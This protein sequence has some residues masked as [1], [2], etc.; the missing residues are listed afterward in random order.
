MA[1]GILVSLGRGGCQA[2]IGVFKTRAF[3]W[4]IQLRIKSLMGILT[5][6]AIF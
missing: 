4:M 6:V 1:R 3:D 2:Q 5:Y